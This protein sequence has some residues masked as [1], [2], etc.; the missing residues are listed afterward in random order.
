[1]CTSNSTLYGYR[2]AAQK[3]QIVV[4]TSLNQ[5][6]SVS[7]RQLSSFQSGPGGSTPRWCIRTIAARRQEAS[8]RSTGVTSKSRQAA[9]GAGAAALRPRRICHVNPKLSSASNRHPP[10]R[11]R[12][13]WCTVRPTL[14]TCRYS[15]VEANGIVPPLRHPFIVKPA[16]AARCVPLESDPRTLPERVVE[17][18]KTAGCARPSSS[19]EYT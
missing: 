15:V 9:H 7:S 19:S 2:A 11:A 5:S 10:A 3:E 18:R 12:R 1:M 8:T 16:I 13:P 17:L 6:R 14:A 4:A